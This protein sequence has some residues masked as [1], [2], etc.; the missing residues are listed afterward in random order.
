MLQKRVAYHQRNHKLLL[1]VAAFSSLAQLAMQLV[2][3]TGCSGIRGV[4]VSV[5][6]ASTGAV[7][8]DGPGL[9]G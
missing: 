6:T 7:V 5:S 2:V 4:L 8:Q 9:A 1:T 3:Q